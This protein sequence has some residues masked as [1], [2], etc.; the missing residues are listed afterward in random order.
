[1]F[2][3]V[4]REEKNPKKIRCQRH[5]E[6]SLGLRRKFLA[7]SDILDE[8]INSCLLSSLNLSFQRILKNMKF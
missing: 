6:W 1:M 2:R 7:A 4:P 3:I 5:L 8:E